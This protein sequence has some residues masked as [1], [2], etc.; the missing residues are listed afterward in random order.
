[1]RGLPDMNVSPD[2]GMCS[3]RLVLRSV[4]GLSKELPI[5]VPS[6]DSPAISTVHAR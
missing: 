3:G 1:M 6:P 4:T 5:A 2:W